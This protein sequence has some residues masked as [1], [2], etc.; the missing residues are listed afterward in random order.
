MGTSSQ[1]QPT[2][3]AP[4]QVHHNPQPIMP[5]QLPAQPNHNPNNITVNLIQ[6][7]LNPN[8]KIEKKKCN[9]LRLRSG[10]VISPKEYT[11]LPQLE[12]EIPTVPK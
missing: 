12:S 8:P 4:Y 1:N 5:P 11:A 6:L 10:H 2:L 9:E 3:L 7:V